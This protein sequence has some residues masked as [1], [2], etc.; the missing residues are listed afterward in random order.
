M[1][2]LNLIAVIRYSYFKFLFDTNFKLKFIISILKS[3]TK[4]KCILLLVY[5]S[6]LKSEFHLVLL[7]YV[8]LLCNFHCSYENQTLLHTR[9]KL[10]NLKIY[11]N[12]YMIVCLIF[13]LYY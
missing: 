6:Q 5:F 7:I 1:Y 9:V 3:R 13:L 12:T 4:L 8:D 2:D 11:K 10:Q